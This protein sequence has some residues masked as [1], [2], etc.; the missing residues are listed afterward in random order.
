MKN[1]IVLHVLFLLTLGIAVSPVRAGTNNVDL[2]TAARKQIGVT[3]RDEPG[4]IVTVTAAGKL[5]HIMLV[6]DRKTK[7]GTPLVIHNIGEGTQEEALL[8]T[9]PMTGHYR[10]K[11][12]VK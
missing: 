6:S 12:D 1:K 2:V 4:D 10:L 11:M 5:P 7:D 8:F 3:V 9:Y